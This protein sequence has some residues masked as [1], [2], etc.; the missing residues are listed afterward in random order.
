MNKFEL[1]EDNLDETIDKIVEDE[2]RRLIEL[3][4]WEGFITALLVVGAG[5][6]ATFLRK[7]FA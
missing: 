2:T 6:Y 1:L 7:I 3:V 5:Q 4:Y